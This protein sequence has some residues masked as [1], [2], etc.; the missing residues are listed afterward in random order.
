MQQS[1]AVVHTLSQNVPLE[2]SRS[3][4]STT[5]L[6]Y[7]DTTR[8]IELYYQGLQSICDG[9]YQKAIENFTA[10]HEVYPNC[11]AV[12][13][14]RGR[15]LVLQGERGQGLA[16]LLKADQLSVNNK[17]AITHENHT[18]TDIL[19][20]D[21]STQTDIAPIATSSVQTDSST[22][23]ASE[24]ATQTL[25]AKIFSTFTQTAALEH[26][27]TGIQT[28]SVAIGS[29][30]QKVQ[31]E[32]NVTNQ[33]VQTD[34]IA[35]NKNY[36]D[37]STSTDD[38][39][40]LGAGV[41]HSDILDW[42]VA[43]HSSSESDESSYSESV[44]A[45]SI[46]EEEERFLSDESQQILSQ[47]N[48]YFYNTV[49]EIDEMLASDLD[50]EVT[51]ALEDNNNNAFSQ[52]QQELESEKARLASASMELA[53]HST[54]NMTG[55]IISDIDK[56]LKDAFSLSV[57]S[58]GEEEQ[59][60]ASSIVGDHTGFYIS[61]FIGKTIQQEIASRSGYHSK[62]RGAIIGYD[63]R[64]N[65]SILLGFNF[66]KANS[67][68]KFRNNKL[69]DTASLK[70][71]FYSL[72][73]LYTP[74]D[75]NIF[76]ST[77]GIYGISD[78]K[79]SAKRPDSQIATSNHKAYSNIM[80]VMFG[81]NYKPISSLSIKPIFGIK[82]SKIRDASYREYGAGAYNLALS[83]TKSLELE[84]ITG[85][86]LSNSSVHASSISITPEMHCFLH[87]NIK[88]KNPNITAKFLDEGALLSSGPINRSKLVLS[89]GAGLNVAA[90]NLEI[91]LF[92]NGN[93]ARKYMSHA[94][95]IKLKI[96]I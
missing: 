29:T 48:S 28:N 26:K 56:R 1:Q 9:E 43:S 73:G 11:A 65:D 58:A 30:E 57:V 60:R 55:S 66:T 59:E 40:V 71:N 52:R 38:L 72:Y 32:A 81:Y 15:A 87:K 14:E 68:I 89:Y 84:T 75:Q 50:E 78:I 22:I 53:S 45:G 47:D 4:S 21:Q 3:T 82:Y 37:T 54:S 90:K 94:G 16:A 25:P 63:I 31:T 2:K 93:K 49:A 8:L 92:Y 91:G 27:N 74:S 80:Q 85:L 17:Y 95:S 76:I 10:I 96:N 24:I 36:S 62:N 39:F 64:T 51:H 5:A 6:S 35:T 69:G 7:H 44:S 67:K 70:G 79:S 23:G 12:W 46:D 20:I 13:R 19:K 34:D 88:S 18:Q 41:S 33:D 42:E 86:K 77:I 83:G 61:P